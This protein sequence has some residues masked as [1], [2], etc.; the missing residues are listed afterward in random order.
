MLNTVNVIRFDNSGDACSIQEMKSFPDNPDGN[1]EAEK[2]FAEWARK[3]DS[4]INDEDMYVYS[5]D[6]YFEDKEYN[7]IVLT[8]ST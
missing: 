4:T 5:G 7:L 2:L 3:L 8:H 1:K 6:G